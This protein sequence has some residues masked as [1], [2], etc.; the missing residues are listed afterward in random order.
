VKLL[1]DNDLPPKLARG[2]AAIFEDSHT[3]VHMRDKFGTG[4]LPD[5]EWITRLG[6]EG[7]WCVLS[8]DMRIAKR[9][10]SRELFRRADL[11]GFFPLPAVR[12]LP[13]HGFAARVLTVWPAIEDTAR[14]NRGCFELGIKGSKLRSIG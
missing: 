12:A 8:G 9:K 3:I 13:L 2:L 6:K 1:V 14:S 7:D 5:E 11:V 4:S 10:P